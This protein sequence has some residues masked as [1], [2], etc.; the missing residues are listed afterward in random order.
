[1]RSFSYCTQVDSLRVAVLDG[2]VSGPLEQR[3]RR[4][5]GRGAVAGDEAAA[6][7][8]CV[9]DADPAALKVVQVVEQV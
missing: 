8:G 4:V 5:P 9:H 1:M 7:G 6:G 3:R 2:L